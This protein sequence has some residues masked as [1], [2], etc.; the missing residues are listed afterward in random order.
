MLRNSDPL[1][2]KMPRIENSY[3]YVVEVSLAQTFLNIL[4][5]LDYQME[6]DT[7]IIFLLKLKAV[8][9]LEYFTKLGLFEENGPHLVEKQITVD[10][11]IGSPML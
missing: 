6:D 9:S 5:P 1:F 2:F 8:H 4:F 10:L 7:N 3:A 11:L